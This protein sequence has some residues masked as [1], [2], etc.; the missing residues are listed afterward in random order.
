MNQIIQGDCLEKLRNLPDQC[1][2]TC[3]TSP[4]YFGL[5]DYGVDGQIGLEETLEAYVERLVDVFREVR[6]VLRDDGTLWLN[7]GDSYSAGGR[8]G[9]GKQDTIKGSINLWCVESRRVRTKATPRSALESSICSPSR[10]MDFA[11]GHHLAQTPCPR[12]SRTVAPR[13]MSTS[14]C[15]RNLL[16]IISNSNSNLPRGMA[17]ETHFTKAAPKTWPG[18]LTNDGSAVKTGN[19][20][21]TSDQYGQ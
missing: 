13:R 16:D 19:I 21:A 7:L 15:S 5:R 4:P 3:V 6:R 11:P 10:W 1:V 2:H 9:G 20:C 12:A 8:G 18:V 17:D 14:S